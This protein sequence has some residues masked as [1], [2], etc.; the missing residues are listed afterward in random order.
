MAS[1]FSTFSSSSP[2]K[3]QT[4]IL[5]SHFSYFNNKYFFNLNP[6]AN[7]IQI[8]KSPIKHTQNFNLI[9]P[10]PTIKLKPIEYLN[11][12]YWSS[13]THF[14][15]KK[16]NGYALWISNLQEKPYNSYFILHFTSCIFIKS[17]FPMVSKICQNMYIDI[18]YANL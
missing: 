3:S 13:I 18:W 17:L 11:S 15:Q 1:I 10:Y 5:L 6:Q 9:F 4:R 14:L 7:N 16:P 12:I 2:P 8:L